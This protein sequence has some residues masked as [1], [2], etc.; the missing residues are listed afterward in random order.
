MTPTGRPAADDATL[1]AEELREALAAHG[2]VL[3]SL[4]VDLVTFASTSPEHRAGLVTLGRCNLGTARALT[5]VL[6]KAAEG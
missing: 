4:G 5:T 6:R 3:P 2:I 1:I